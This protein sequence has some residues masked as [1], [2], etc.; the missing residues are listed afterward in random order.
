MGNVFVMIA[1]RDQKTIHRLDDA[2]TESRIIGRAEYQSAI[3]LK[4]PAHLG[5]QRV[6]ERDVLDHFRTDQTIETIILERKCEGRA[7]QERNSIAVHEAKLHKIE[8]HSDRVVEGL[9]D[10]AGTTS[11]VQDALVAASPLQHD[12]VAAPLPVALDRN[13]AVKRALIVIRGIERVADLPQL[14]RGLEK[15]DA[16]SE[17]SRMRAA[18]AARKVNERHLGD[19]VAARVRLDQDFFLNF[20]VLRIEFEVFAPPPAP[21]EPEAARQIAHRHRE[22]P[23]QAE[24]QEIAELLSEEAAVCDSTAGV[25]RRDHYIGASAGPPSLGH[26]VGLV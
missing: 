1:A 23:A 17:H 21:I 24:I 16:E 12:T 10:D 18:A 20:E 19:A 4:H 22:H 26:E 8:I 25:S 7:L 2:P 11:S 3:G 6:I 5:E 14:E 15:I 13:D 9:N